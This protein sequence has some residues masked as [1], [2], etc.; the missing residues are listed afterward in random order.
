MRTRRDKRLWCIPPAMLRDPG[1][2]LEGDRI[3][4]ETP[5]ALGLLLW[6]TVL[7]VTLWATTPDE[8][9]ANLFA[10]GTAAARL[11]LLAAT[12]LPGKVAAAVDTLHGMLA[13]PSQV[14]AEIVALCCLET[15]AWAHGVGLPHTAVA[16]AQA[17]A[18]AAPQFGEAALHTGVYA[19][20][21]GQDARAETWLRR[22]IDL[23]RRERDGVTYSSALGELGTLYERR[24]N[25]P[26]AERLYRLA[27]RA[28]RRYGARPAR[29]RAT[30]G[31]F[32]LARQQGDEASA[33]QFAL[34]AQRAYE[35]DAAGGADLLLDL[36]RFWTDTGEPARAQAALRRLVP[37]L[38]RMPPA[39]QLA[40]FA[41]T[42]R[43]R[44]EWGNLRAG[45]WAVSAAW[46]L[47][48]DEAINDSVRYAA[49]VDLAHAARAAGDL[50]GFTRAKRLVLRLASQADFPGAAERMAKLWPGGDDPAAATERATVKPGTKRIGRVLAGLVLLG[51]TGCDWILPELDSDSRLCNRHP[52]AAPLTDELAI[53][54]VS[55]PYAA[56]EHRL[57]LDRLRYL[58]SRDSSRSLNRVVIAATPPSPDITTL[59]HGDTV[60]AATSFDRL[61]RGGGYESSIPEWAA[62]ESRCFH[63]AWVALHRV[64]SI[65][66]VSEGAP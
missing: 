25:A 27:C 4:E 9:R 54:R 51:F 16:F 17:G 11:A 66:R 22:A 47:L 64:R 15:A 65:R 60:L 8:K 24:E 2:G 45:P 31:L 48:G 5:A 63:G 41:L 20:G 37:A 40:A 34:S 52:G 55:E 14:D 18:V 33:A 10:D 35:P 29:M 28:A 26:A 49:A 12:E 57:Y 21:A 61:I 1:D 6:R 32:R 23:S 36:A 43:A 7:D 3:L 56:G 30:H 13:D 59:T 44:G 50:A 62:N 58:G 39:A 46:A 53:V 38:L 19:R 42:A